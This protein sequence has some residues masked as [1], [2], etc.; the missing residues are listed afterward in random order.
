MMYLFKLS[1]MFC[2]LNSAKYLCPCKT[3]SPN[4]KIKNNVKTK[5]TPKVKNEDGES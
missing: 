1:I 3:K 5:V 4:P 2:P